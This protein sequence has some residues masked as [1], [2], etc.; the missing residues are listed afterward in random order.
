MEIEGKLRLKR[1][2][3]KRWK[4]RELWMMHE[5]VLL[6]KRIAPFQFLKRLPSLDALWDRAD[7]IR[8]Y[9]TKVTAKS[10]RI[11]IRYLK[12]DI[13]SGKITPAQPDTEWVCPSDF[14]RWAISREFPIPEELQSLSEGNPDTSGEHPNS[15]S[16]S[17]ESGCF[18]CE[19]VSSWD[20]V[21]LKMVHDNYVE[22]TVMDKVIDNLEY[23]QIGLSGRG[24]GPSLKWLL[25]KELAKGNGMLQTDN[26]E[27]KRRD[28]LKKRIS[29]LRKDLKKIF[30]NI[31]DDPF[32]PWVTVNGYRT[33]FKLYSKIEEQDRS[34]SRSK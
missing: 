22:I 8:E 27:R 3:Y 29:Q 7:I 5:G 18:T 28:D 12:G 34:N 13:A 26:L 21:S 19:D 25:L 24:K 31:M 16:M 4:E 20:Q 1:P 9:N 6:I 17:R 2:D 23:S 30:P 15:P 11:I 32:E 33:R 10:L 14:I